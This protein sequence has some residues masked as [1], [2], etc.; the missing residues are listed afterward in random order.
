M[1]IVAGTALAIAL[2]FLFSVNQ[3]LQTPESAQ[4]YRGKL[5]ISNI[6]GL[7]PDKKDGDGFISLVSLD[8]KVLK[9]KLIKGLN[10]PKGI[11]FCDGKL[12]VADIDQVVVAEPETGRVIKKVE[13]PGAKFLNDTACHKGKVFVSDTQTNSIYTVDSKSYRVKLFLRSSK[14]QG[15]NGLAFKDGKLLVA[16][17]GGGK[18]LEVDGEVRVLASGFENLDGV[19][20]TEDGT[21]L[22]SDFS[23]GKIYA[24]KNGKVYPLPRDFTS[25]ADIGYCNGKLFVPE[26][27]MN[28]VK[29]LRVKR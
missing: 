26:F 8:G 14:L 4:C 3:G 9:R 18:L 6:G 13:V 16:S 21:V 12:F 24:Y 5:Y 15:P 27:L 20:V 1:G 25:P 7:P 11:C 28:D 2:A 10:A 22:F 17:W 29:V 23:K 19:A